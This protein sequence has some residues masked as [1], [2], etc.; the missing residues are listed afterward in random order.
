MTVAIGTARD[1]SDILGAPRWHQERALPVRRFSPSAIIKRARPDSMAHPRAVGDAR[2]GEFSAA[3]D[4]GWRPPLFIGAAES[5][6]RSVDIRPLRLKK[7]AIAGADF[8]RRS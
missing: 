5:V 1:A 6:R 2:R 8:V 7:K 3:K 4:H